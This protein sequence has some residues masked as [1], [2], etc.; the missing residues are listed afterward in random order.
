MRIRIN[1][2]TGSILDEFAKLPSVYRKYSEVEPIDKENYSKTE[3]EDGS[4]TWRETN[5]S[6]L[7]R[8]KAKR[9]K[10]SI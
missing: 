8:M 6:L 2:A 10:G 7:K 3:W 4:V 5:K 9:G 1:K